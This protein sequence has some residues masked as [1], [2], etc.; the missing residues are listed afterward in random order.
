MHCAGNVHGEAL[1]CPLRLSLD[2]LNSVHTTLYDI[3]GD[4]L[5]TCQTKSATSQV[6]DWVVYKM[7]SLLGSV[8]HRVNIHK[9][10][11]ATGK[12]RGDL[13]IKDYVV[14]Q[15]PQSQDN[16]LPPPR[17]LIADFT[18]TH[19]RFGRSHLRPMGQLTNTSHSDGAPGLGAP[20]DPDGAPDDPDGSLKTMVRITIRHY[21]NLYLNRPDPI[22]FIPLTVETTGLKYDDFVRLL[23]W[24]S[25][26]EASALTNHPVSCRRNQIGFVSLELHV[27]LI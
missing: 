4:Y 21:H 15:K 10:T 25:H 1:V 27:S 19:V 18:M 23:F 22:V 5:Q 12:E 17:T 3:F 20:D 11:P 8:G 7:G 2:L 26:R 13:E 6:H 9:I 16:R 14:L 24:Y